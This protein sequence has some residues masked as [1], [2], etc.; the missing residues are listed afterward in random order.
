MSENRY[1]CGE[2]AHTGSESQSRPLNCG[3]RN[4]FI[5]DANSTAAV[6][7]GHAAGVYVDDERMQG[8]GTEA[9]H[10]LTTAISWAAAKRGAPAEIVTNP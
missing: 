6:A 10:L 5:T 7:Y 2:A 9:G 8:L 4:R 1:D 3:R